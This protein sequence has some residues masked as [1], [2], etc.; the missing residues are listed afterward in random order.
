METHQVHPQ[1]MTCL[2]PQLPHVVLHLL[3][4]PPSLL[5]TAVAKLT[6]TDLT[7]SMLTTEAATERA[8]TQSGAGT[9]IIRSIAE[10]GGRSVSGAGTE[11]GHPKMA[12]TSGGSAGGTRRR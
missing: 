4:L 5:L 9:V 10:V 3:H 1:H 7:A 2:S 11:T 12:L 6:K 8:K